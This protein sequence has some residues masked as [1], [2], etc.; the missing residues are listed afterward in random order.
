MALIKRSIIIWGAK[1]RQPMERIAALFSCLYISILPHIGRSF[2]LLDHKI[3]Y[4]FYRNYFP[5]AN[6]AGA[7]SLSTL[8]RCTEFRELANRPFWYLMSYIV[9]SLANR[10]V[11]FLVCTCDVLYSLC[12]TFVPY[13]IRYSPIHTSAGSSRWCLA[14]SPAGL[15][16]KEIAKDSNS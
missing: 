7:Q 3:L 4:S 10:R 2:F 11:G 14:L 15:L 16:E 9:C 8:S 12:H 13:I 6:M 1:F 5:R